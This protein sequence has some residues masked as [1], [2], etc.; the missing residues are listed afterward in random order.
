MHHGASI[1]KQYLLF[2]QYFTDL[3][4]KSAVKLCDIVQNDR[5]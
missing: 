2:I 4:T 3:N 5:N 1:L